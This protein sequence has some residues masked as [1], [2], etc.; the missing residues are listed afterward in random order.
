MDTIPSIM[1]FIRNQV[2]SHA[3]NSASLPQIRILGFLSANPGA[4]LSKVAEHLGVSNA[5]ASAIVERLVQ[6]K[7]VE[8][9]EH[10]EE[11]RFVELKLTSEG[12][13]QF[14]KL[15]LHASSQLSELLS[16]LPAQKVAKV[17]EAMNILKEIFGETK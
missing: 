16:D 4:S 1:R 3:G 9:K 15:H 2:K 13:S 7:L 14:Q 17:I 5:T 10:P 12:V 6:K 11:R 8:R